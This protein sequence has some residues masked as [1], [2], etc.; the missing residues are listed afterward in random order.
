VRF[1]FAFEFGGIWWR[2]IN[3]TIQPFNRVYENLHNITPLTLVA[4]RQIRRQKKYAFKYSAVNSILCDVIT[5]V[6]DRCKYENVSVN[7]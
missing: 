5:D 4:H 3:R 7:K 2:R 1:L 6:V